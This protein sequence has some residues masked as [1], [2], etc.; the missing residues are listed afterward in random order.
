MNIIIWVAD[1]LR[2]DHLSLYGYPGATSPHLE[3]LARDGVV[4][5]RA[6]AQA[7]WTRPSAGSLL[8]GCYP[9]THGVRCFEHRLSPT[10]PTLPKLLARQG[11]VASIFSAIGMVSATT[12]FDHDVNHFVELSG[13]L[14]SSDEIWEAARP[15]ITRQARARQPFFSLLWS[16]DTHIPFLAERVLAH[17]PDTLVEDRS[18]SVQTTQGIWSASRPEH[19]TALLKAHDAGILDTDASIGQLVRLL[20]EEDIYDDTL[21]IFLSDHGEV[22]NEHSRG[23]HTHLSPWLSLLNRLPKVRSLLRRYRLINSHGW[24]GHLDLIPY[25]EVLH[26]PLLIKFPR[27]RWRGRRVSQSVQ[28][29]D[30]APTILHEIGLEARELQGESLLPLLQGQSVSPEE[31]YIFS[32]SQTRL[33]RTRYISVQYGAWKLVRILAPSSD[34]PGWQRLRGANVWQSLLMKKEI[35]LH[36]GDERVDHRKKRPHIC[37]QLNHV[38]DAWWAENQSLAS[39]EVFV[40]E[41]S[42]L[43]DRLVDL[44]YL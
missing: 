14:V 7:T 39:E 44:G 23:E 20:K 33:D 37:R 11:I 42:V 30:L 6:Y 5:D 25:E 9:A 26:I 1:S 10:L 31:P 19:Q 22:F 38:L 3:E 35:L 21:F 4:F 24:L 15:W 17:F 12:G 8:T 36:I 28:E 43:K 2:Y 16:I 32:D 29:I 27:S 34:I 40:E 18:F 41:E 13:P